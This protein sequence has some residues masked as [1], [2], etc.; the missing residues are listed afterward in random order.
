MNPGVKPGCKD[1]KGL[2]SN[3]A[4][5]EKLNAFQVD[6]LGSCQH[7]KMQQCP[8]WAVD[9]PAGSLRRERYQGTHTHWSLQPDHLWDD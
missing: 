2:G 5:Q 6:S 9:V 3:G 8:G 1:S 4:G 7:Q